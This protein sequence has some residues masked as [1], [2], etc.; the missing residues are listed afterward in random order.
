MYIN[1]RLSVYTLQF[2][3]SSCGRVYLSLFCRSISAISL[4]K[5][6]HSICVWFGCES[7]FILMVYCMIG[8][9]LISSMCEGI[10]SCGMNHDC[11]E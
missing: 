10:Y 5:S 6:S 8:I 1:N 9:S 2:G 3:S 11:N 4:L 7:I